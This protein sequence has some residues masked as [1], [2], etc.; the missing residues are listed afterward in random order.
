MF[1]PSTWYVISKNLSDIWGECESAANTIQTMT[2]IKG[3]DKSIDDWYKMQIQSIPQFRESLQKFILDKTDKI[4]EESKIA[5]RKALELSDAQ[6]KKAFIDQERVIQQNRDE[7]VEQSIK[8]MKKFNSV[9]MNALVD[10]AVLKQAQ[11]INTIKVN[12]EFNR[13]YSTKKTTKP[14]YDAIKKQ[15]EEGIR[16]GV[17]VIY[18]NGR[19]MPFKS[20]MEMATRTTIQNEAIN[21]MES[22]A[23]NMGIIFFLASEHADCADDH[24][25]YQGKIYIHA[26]WQSIITDGELK[27]QVNDF[28]SRKG[29]KTLQWVKGPPVYFNTRPNCRH[30]FIPITIKQALGNIAELKEEVK[31]SRGTYKQENYKDLKRQ[32]EIERKIRLYKDRMNHNQV[33][34]NEIT[35]ENIK[36]KLA[37]EIK[38]D[39]FYMKAWQREVRDLIVRNP[40]LSRNYAR[41]NVDKMAH[42]LGV[43]LEK[44]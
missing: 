10:F 22:T 34:Y 6:M 19:V 44:K 7:E 14:L 15:T 33:I 42:D 3:Y 43:S 30:F 35:D 38:K 40:N 4:D 16:N 8:N 36:Q 18:S 27:N 31:I 23:S 41:E 12:A 20:Y 28:V 29:I 9:Q 11:E 32:R 37:F 1:T 39:K 21:R 26:N 17:P 25:D 5:I 24:A 13:K 2:L